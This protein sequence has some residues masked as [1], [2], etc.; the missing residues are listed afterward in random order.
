MSVRSSMKAALVAV[1]M[2]APALQA[3]ALSIEEATIADIQAADP[4]SPAFARTAGR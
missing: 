3:N 1:A 4:L 2:C